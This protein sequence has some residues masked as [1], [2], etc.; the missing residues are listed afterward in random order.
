MKNYQLR[1]ALAIITSLDGT[2]SIDSAGIVSIKQKVG[3]IIISN[4]YGGGTSFY[5]CLTTY[6]AFIIDFHFEEADLFH[7]PTN[8]PKRT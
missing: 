3:C 4:H 1:N 7:Q 8:L 2:V 6:A 5:T